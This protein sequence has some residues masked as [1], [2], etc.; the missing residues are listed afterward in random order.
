MHTT[1]RTRKKLHRKRSIQREIT[2]SFQ[3]HVKDITLFSQ[4]FSS[5]SQI[6][7][8]HQRTPLVL[9]D[10]QSNAKDATKLRFPSRP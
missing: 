8:N 9:I 3:G 4:H 1:G 2:H 7:E 10:S 5:V 6:I